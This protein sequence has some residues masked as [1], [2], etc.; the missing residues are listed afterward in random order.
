M[1]RKPPL[2]FRKT[3]R[4]ACKLGKSNATKKDRAKSY[5]TLKKYIRERNAANVLDL[6]LI[7]QLNLRL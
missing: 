4:A 7:P 5:W 1:W 6:D 3:V 2:G